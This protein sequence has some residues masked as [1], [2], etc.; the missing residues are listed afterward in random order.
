MNIMGGK[1]AIITGPTSGIG[2]QIA[3][4]LGAVGADIVLGCRDIVRGRQV[5]EEI[6]KNFGIC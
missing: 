5:V 2:K 1:L 4:Q 6:Y 3:V